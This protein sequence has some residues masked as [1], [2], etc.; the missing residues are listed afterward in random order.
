VSST[1]SEAD[2]LAYVADM[3]GVLYKGSEYRLGVFV[4]CAFLENI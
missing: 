1:Y 4:Y 2:G 3:D